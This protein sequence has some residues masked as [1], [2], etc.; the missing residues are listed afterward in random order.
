[1]S[2][3]DLSAVV[4]PFSSV[5]GLYFR[6]GITQF[7]TKDEVVWVNNGALR[8]TGSRSYDGLGTTFGIG[9]DWKL[10]PGALRVE[11]NQMFSIS[12]LRDNDAMT[13]SVG[14]LYAF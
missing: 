7:D 2:G 12:D 6:A 1:M 5:R 8:F 4:S 10:G 11:A 14:Y 3:V 9:Y 13:Y